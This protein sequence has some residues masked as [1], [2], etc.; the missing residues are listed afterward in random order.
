[1]NIQLSEHFTYAKLLR[2]T[3]PTIITMIF[4]SIYSIVD[5]IF[6]SNFVGKTPFAAINLIFPFIMVLGAVG[7]MLGTGGS[8]LVAKTLG[9]GKT[10]KSQWLFFYDNPCRHPRGYSANHIGAARYPPYGHF[11]R[12]GGRNAG[13]CC[14]LCPCFT[15][16][17][18]S[19]YFAVCISE[20]SCHCG[21]AQ[22]RLSSDRWRWCNQHGS[23][24]FL[25]RRFSLGCHW[26]CI[27]HLYQS[28]CRR[29]D[30]PWS[31][32]SAPMAVPCALWQPDWR[33]VRCAAPV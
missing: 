30:T 32:L 26:R 28:G 31:I 24:P 2:F 29:A 13:L 21:T 12:R 14:A 19:F 18:C 8:A 15:A 5:G 22:F 20:L 33:C 7:F 9:E 17:A 23:G 10:G 6:I 16:R 1:M 3:L 11:V 4:T 27:G 25:Y